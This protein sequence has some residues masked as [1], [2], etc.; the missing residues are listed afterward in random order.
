[1]FKVAAAYV[2][3]AWLIL[4]VCDVVLGNIGAPEWVFKAILLLLAVA[5]PVVLVLAWAFDMTPDGLVRTDS[6]DHETDA[7]HLPDSNPDKTAVTA[8]TPD[9][10]VA[11][12]PF[13]NMS[14]DPEN[15]YFSD[16]LSEELLN[17]LANIDA[18][19]VAARTSSFY[20]KGHTGDIA[21]IATRLGVATILEGSVRQSGDRVRITAQLINAADGYHLWSETYDRELTDIFA[22]QD[23]IASSVAS[24]LRV[25][26]LGA[27]PD[28]PASG[29]TNDPEAFKFYLKGMHAIN[30][31]SDKAALEDAVRSFQ[32]AIEI[33]HS[34]AKAF[35]GLAHT[36]DQLATN[37]FI[38]YEE[39]VSNGLQAASKAIELDPNLASGYLVQGRML[40]HYKLDQQGALHAIEKAVSLN[41]GNSE[42]QQSFGYV[43]CLL[44]DVD[45]SVAAARKAVELDPVSKSTHHMLGH[46]LY[47]GRRY[48]EAIREFRQLLEIDPDFPRPRYTLGMC[49]FMK[50]DVEAAYNE[51]S[52]EPLGW[53]RLS[54]SA[55][56]LHHLGRRAEAEDH[57]AQLVRADD[58]EYAIYQQGQIHAQWGQADRAIQCL[59]RA[60]ELGDPGVSQVLVDPLLDPIRG[61][62]QFKGVLKVT[63]YT[64]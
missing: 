54:G 47:F 60:R 57:L 32:S 30:R 49:L 27:A 6:K 18:L 55:I 7:G 21:S 14:G 8:V 29:E 23:E 59:H 39:G 1:V 19:K 43:S 50:G 36:W 51:V 12:L 58:E 52:R 25:T 11:V 44:G 16:G 22:V 45:T 61:N 33:D 26:L 20:F 64:Q 37:S 17:V 63:G 62:P 24:A 9:A 10:S 2:V 42:A 38:K 13:V 34:Y 4:Q 3:T 48:D 46:I 15:E 31:G 56:L 28:T 41:P 40:L 35:A 5:L 53:M